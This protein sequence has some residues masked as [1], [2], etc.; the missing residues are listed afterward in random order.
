M[1]LG[2]ASPLPGEE[3]EG[4]VGGVEVKEVVEEEV[5]VVLV[6]EAEE[7]GGEAGPEVVVEEGVAV[8]LVEEEEEGETNLPGRSIRLCINIHS[9]TSL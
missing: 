5:G 6:E 2:E 8:V 7:E 1:D 9:G 3:E 4:E